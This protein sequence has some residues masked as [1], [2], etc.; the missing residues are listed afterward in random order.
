MSENIKVKLEVKMLMLA[1]PI[2][3]SIPPVL[4]PGLSGGGGEREHGGQEKIEQGGQEKIEQGGQEE[5]EQGG[6]TEV[7]QEGK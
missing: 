3:G 6:K 7:E 4:L 1:C 5:I 2:T